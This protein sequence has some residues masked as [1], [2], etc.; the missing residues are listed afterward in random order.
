MNACVVIPSAWAENLI[1]C[2]QAIL[3][4]EPS[5]PPSEIIVVDDG[6]RAHAEPAL[7]AVTWIAGI[8]PFVFA[9]NVNLG[10]QAASAADVIVLGD[11][12][13]LLT[14]HGLTSLVQQARRHPDVGVC[15]AG[16]VGAVC[17]PRQLAR[18]PCAFRYEADRLAFVA[19]Y[20]SRVVIECVGLLDEQ[21]TGYG[22]D[23]FDYCRRVKAAGFTLAIW[24]GCVVDHTG[25]VALSVYRTREDWPA[26]M[27]QNL[28]RYREKWPAG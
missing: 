4:H 11:D 20:L 17:N 15:S 6:A 25:E 2:V 22:F 7:P 14:P 1:P 23:D 18:T 13:H 26:L 3:T 12:A 16:I 21:F 8:Q 28:E 19:V 10:I 27:H 5:I 9:R 24:D